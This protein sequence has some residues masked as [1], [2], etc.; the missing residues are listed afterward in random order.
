MVEAELLNELAIRSATTRVCVAT[1]A[2][3][4]ARSSRTTWS[5]GSEVVPPPRD[6]ATG[7]WAPYRVDSL[8]LRA[9]ARRTASLRGNL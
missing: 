4:A 6:P 9:P 2:T 3:S 7:D 8:R 1:T 5:P